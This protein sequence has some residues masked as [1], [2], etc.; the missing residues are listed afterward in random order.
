MEK[1]KVVAYIRYSSHA[2][3]DGN[4]VAAQISCI[5][6]Y[7]DRHNM[8]VIEFY[9]DMAKTGRNTKRNDYQRL[10]DDITTGQLQSNTVIVRALDRL[11]R[12]TKNGLIDVDVFEKHKIR[13]I[14]ITDGIDT[15]DGNYSKFALTI[16]FAAAE[17][18]SNLLSKNTR[19]ALLECAKD[20]KHLGG[21]PPIG[22]SVTPEGYYEIDE[23]KAPIIRDIYRFYLSGMGYDDILTHM[24]RSGYKTNYGNDFSKSAINAILTNPKYMGTYIYDKTCPKDS[25]GKRNSHAKKDKYVEI[26]NGM[27]AIISEAD[28]N[29]VK[30]KMS[31]NA[32]KHTSRNGKQYYPL[33]GKIYCVECG[34][35]FS[36]NINNSNGRKYLQY[37]RSCKCH[38]KS[39]RL[40]QLNRAVFY[41]LQQCIFCPENKDKIVKHINA[42]LNVQKNLQTE[43]IITLTNR[44]NG[45]ENAQ[46]RL[47]TCL[48]EGKAAKTILDKMQKNETELTSLQKR[49]A[50]KNRQIIN[51][52]DET[53][54]KLI[55]RFVQYMS[56]VKSPETFAL[57]D[58]TIDSITIGEDQVTIHFNN[59]V[60]V[61]ED[62]IQYF[63][64]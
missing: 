31:Q 54:E 42:K 45:L 48:E 57:K 24:K 59:G 22:Y 3:D 46:N 38:V 58:K 25:E 61:D 18:Y 32:T 26:P 40:E 64:I 63:N 30:E 49:L 44:I 60:T 10:I 5:T 15:A 55:Q 33:N 53:Y 50:I 27:P 20:C 62:T 13:L 12:N 9:I 16:K 6:E 11:H 4:S 19:A 7:A 41:A 2:Q 1:T 37:R 21:T 29:K 43:E 51:V 23:T 17:D 28:F 34:K 35:P 39:I 56:D 36:G 47:A 8:E 14:A 52:D